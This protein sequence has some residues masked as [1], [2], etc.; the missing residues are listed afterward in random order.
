M[1]SPRT[2]LLFY[3]RQLR[4]QPLRELM[5]VLGVAA[6]VAL[7]FTMEIS[8]SS[9]TGSF[10]QITRGLAG[11]ATLEMAARTPEG[12]DGEV[13]EQVAR[14]PGVKGVAPILEQRIVA[15]GPAGSRALTLVGADERL[16]ALGGEMAVQFQG[17]GAASKSGLM[18]ISEPT[19]KAIGTRR[20]G[21]IAVKIGER[22]E[23]LSIA[24][25]VPSAKIGSLADSP[26]AAAPLPVVQSLAELPGRV[27]RILIRTPPASKAEVEQAISKRFGGDLNIR[28]IDAEAH[29]LAD[30]ARPEGQLTALFSL[31]SL[32]V[33][34]ILAYN[35]ILLASGERRKFVAYLTQLGAPDVA[36]VASLAFDAFV[37]GLAG[38]AIGLIAGDF[39]SLYAYRAVPGYLS[40]A[41]PIGS[42]RV[43]DLHTVLIAILAGMLAAFVAAALPAIGLLRSSAAENDPDPRLLS[44]AGRPRKSESIVFAAGST[45]FLLSATAS[46]LVPAV[47][48]AALIAL[49]AG[50]VIC[51]PMTVRCLLKL[52]RAASRHSSDP[53]AR[54]AL[55]ELQASPSRSV[56]LLATGAIAVFLMVTIGGAVAD[57]Q[58]AVR[59][60]AGGVVS[61]AEL[62]LNPGGPTNIYSTEPFSYR[63]TERRVQRLSV[64]RS[65]LPYRQ[66]FLDLAERRVWVIGVPAQ[67]PSPIIAS[68]LVEG[69]LPTATR[70]L[71]EGGWAAISQA[72][73]DQRH[74]RLGERFSLP[75]PSG[76]S[77]FR[78]AATISNYGWLPG[79]VVV[80]GD[81]YAR[82]WHST[83]A[84]QLGVMLEPGVSLAQGKHAVER[85]LPHDSALSVQTDD[86]RQAQIS[87]VLGSTLS[88]LN[89]ISTVVL[90][91]AIT[92][93]LAMMVGAVWQRRGRLDALMSIGTSFGQLARLVFYESGSVL[94]AGCLIGMLSGILGQALV[95]GW[96][97][98]TT[99]SP[100][101]FDPAWE[102]GLRTVVVASVISTSV[103]VLAVLRTVGFQPAA[104]FST[105]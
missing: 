95:D 84:S 42:Q 92:T 88:R 66:S 56:A 91:T 6:G 75:T 25:T 82:L 76:S 74:L 94:L 104:S 43:V 58:R 99:G 48:V 39:I 29:L 102:L 62:W 67:A 96:L 19:A 27:T 35:A 60:G 103:A 2:L 18:V 12:F 53:A 38:C 5:A 20:G 8:N 61:N 23:Q 14:M 77:S 45:L 21:V 33:G 100:I 78:L 83:Q 71:R 16:A 90:I 85:A 86:E 59:T 28:P 64:V 22:T 87:T 41:F 36:I 30:A 40:S 80:N 1:I 13:S 101:R 65:V 51:I 55:A 57:V 37:L 89:E 46:L 24:A 34:M 3:T 70:H 10:E 81:D 63:E 26:I 105:E 98:H 49:V 47:S 93:V 54:L 32:V 17:A 79:T 4:V 52:T 73:A 15:V 69:S 50:L 44:L 72:L 11:R 31:I 68:Q 9:V 7:L 97:H